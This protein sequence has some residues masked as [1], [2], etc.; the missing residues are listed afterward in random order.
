MIQIPL[1]Y[2]L[3]IYLD[4][5]FMGAMISVSSAFALH[6]AACIYLFKLGKWK[7]TEV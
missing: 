6:A 2:I 7:T 4:Y 3:A 1:A 5:G